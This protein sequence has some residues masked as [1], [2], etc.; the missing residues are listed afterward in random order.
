[1]RKFRPTIR[2]ALIPGLPWCLVSGVELDVE[3]RHSLLGLNSLIRRSCPQCAPELRMVV[4]ELGHD[5]RAPE[6]LD[7]AL[8]AFAFGVGVALGN[9]VAANGW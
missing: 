6:L 4:L 9:P 3:C 7:T 8:V 5:A 1:M 2:L